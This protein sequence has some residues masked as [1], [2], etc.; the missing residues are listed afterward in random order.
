MKILQLIKNK[1]INKKEIT[2]IK[3]ATKPEKNNNLERNAGIICIENN[4]S[5]GCYGNGGSQDVW[6]IKKQ[7]NDFKIPV[8]GDGSAGGGGGTGIPFCRTCGTQYSINYVSK[9]NC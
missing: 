4:G 7:E 1:F 2:D 8:G 9:C 5:A 6:Y 3:M